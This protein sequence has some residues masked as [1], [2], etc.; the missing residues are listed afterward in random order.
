MYESL[1]FCVSNKQTSISIDNI[2]EKDDN[3]TSKSTHEGSLKISQNEFL[4]LS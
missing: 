4:L 2:P 3:I 1:L